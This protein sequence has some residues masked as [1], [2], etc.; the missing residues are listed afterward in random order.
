MNC[1]YSILE[2]QIFIPSNVKLYIFIL[3][4]YLLVL[5]C[6][7]RQC[8][9]FLICLIILFLTFTSR[10]QNIKRQHVL[11]NS[12]HWLIIR[13]YMEC[14]VLYRFVYGLRIKNIVESC[15]PDP[16]KSSERGKSERHII[17]QFITCPNSRNNIIDLHQILL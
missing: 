2:Y 15:S 12:K 1:R 16:R 3:F 8:L 4:R 14:M 7:Y 11:S 13:S 17:P 5:M 9:F 6:E 10:L